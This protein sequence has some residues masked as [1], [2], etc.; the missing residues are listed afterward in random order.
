[1]ADVW[2]RSSSLHGKN[3]GWEER[4]MPE[5]KWMIKGVVFVMQGGELTISIAFTMGSLISPIRYDH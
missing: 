3:V 4:R 1:M 5:M 2:S